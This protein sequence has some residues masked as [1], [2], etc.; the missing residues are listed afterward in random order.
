MSV[1]NSYFDI[2]NY[3]DYF[4][5][6]TYIQNE[7]WLGISWG[8]NN[9][10]NLAPDTAGGKWRYVMYDTD[11]AFGHF[12]GNVNQN[13]LSRARNPSS[14]NDHASI[15]DHT[16]D[17][18]QFKCHFANR[19]DDLI[20]TTFQ[21]DNFNAVS[22]ELKESIEDAVP[23]THQQLEGGVGTP[24]SSGRWSDLN[25]Y[26]PAIQYSKNRPCQTTPK[27]NAG[28]LRKTSNQIGCS[29]VTIW[30]GSIELYCSQTSLGRCI[31]RRMSRYR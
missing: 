31:P 22:N 25:W 1:F 15:F 4:I 19:Y 7:D 6:Q 28:P 9:V 18:P 20:N 21:S 26:R 16:L 12:G 30:G 3:L 14:S 27:Y 29:S 11:A 5:F 2:N 10:K 8:L 13:Y 17:N 23:L 24:N